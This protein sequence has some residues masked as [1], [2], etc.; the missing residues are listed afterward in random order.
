MIK[1]LITHNNPKS[2]ISE[3]IKTVR[4]NL[5][6]SSIDSDVKTLLITSSIPSEG[7][8]FIASNLATAFAQTKQKVLLVDCDMRKGRLHKIFKVENDKGISNLLVDSNTIKLKPYVKKTD[9]PNVNLISI[10]TIPPNPNELLG[11]EKFN[12]FLEVA[13]KEYDLVIFDSAPV[14]I[15]SDALILAK[16]VDRTIIVAAYRKTPMNEL[17]NTKKQI[18]NVGGKIAGVVVNKKKTNKKE[19][20]NKYYNM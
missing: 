12:E 8:S 7:K 13:K 14:S 1:E 17:E 19:Y 18:L 5:L 2:I 20:Y 4:T 11:S 10:G 15:V 3:T 6:F 9:V 16:K